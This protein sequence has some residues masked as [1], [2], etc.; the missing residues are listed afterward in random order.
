MDRTGEVKIL[1]RD[2]LE[3]PVWQERAK[4][5]VK[6]ISDLQKNERTEESEA[7]EALLN[8]IFNLGGVRQDV[9]EFLLS[10]RFKSTVQ[11]ASVRT[12]LCMA[13]EV[14]WLMLA[15]SALEKD[16]ISGVMYV[17]EITEAYKN[18]I[19][20]ERVREFL[21]RARTA[22]EMCQFRIHSANPDKMAQSNVLE[23]PD[24]M[25]QS[26]SSDQIAQIITTAVV[27]AI[28][29]CMGGS[30]GVC[31]TADQEGK[32]EDYDSTEQNQIQALHDDWKLNEPAAN[33]QKENEE[34]GNQQEEIQE[35]LPHNEVEEEAEAVPEFPDG[36]EIMDG[37]ILVTELSEEEKKYGQRISF[38]QIL[39][40]R[41][42]KKVFAKLGEK[43]QVAKI[44]EIMVERRYGKDRI[45]AVKRLMNGGMSNEFI[46]SLLEKDYPE[47]ELTELT[48]AL[49]SENVPEEDNGTEEIV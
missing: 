21:G 3:L 25:T 27:T 20:L 34:Q 31:V 48:E 41:H 6:M 49:L 40:N 16:D 8:F 42:L 30:K 13:A 5:S 12:L 36:Q 18:G 24:R 4:N 33:V 37:S 1:S 47:A 28:R 22:F 15:V 2:M 39:L 7:Q 26:D 32:T 43:E 35:D 38:F 9:Y 19:A 29:E 10:P 23:H 17:E 44:F 46:F 14:E 45:L 11:V